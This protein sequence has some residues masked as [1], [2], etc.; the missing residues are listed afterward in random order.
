MKFFIPTAETEEHER[1][2]YEAI[3]KF[4]SKELG[5]VFTDQKNFSIDY[6]HDGKEYHAE[7][8]QPHALNDEIVFAILY[9]QAFRIYHVCTPNRGVARGMSILVGKHS[10]RK[11]VNFD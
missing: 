4:L 3:Q 5:A 11:I 9:D 1:H 7:V 10:V 6:S 2:V 8:G